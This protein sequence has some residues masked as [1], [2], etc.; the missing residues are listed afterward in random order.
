MHHISNPSILYF[1]TPV[2]L[3]GTTNDDDTFNLA[4][5]SSVFWLGYR[6]MIGIAAHSKTTE[7]ILRT[8]ECVLNLPSVDQVGAVDRLALLTGSNPVPAG[9]VLKGYEHEADKFGRAGLTPIASTIVKAPRVLECPVHLEAAFVAI[10]PFA[11]ETGIGNIRS[12]TLELKILRVHLDESIVSD[13]NPNHVDPDKWRP[14]MMSFQ[15][16]YGL[17][18]QVHPSKLASVPEQL[19]R[20]ND[21]ESALAAGM[22]S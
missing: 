3:V 8:K 1:G 22:V 10:H 20:T 18:A 17:G 14:L 5:I 7:N 4:P 21:T 12:V 9:K 2:V 6:C 19:Y 11:A 16:F 13:E 15:Q